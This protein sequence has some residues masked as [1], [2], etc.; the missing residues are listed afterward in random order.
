MSPFEK[1]APDANDS[2]ASQPQQEITGKTISEPHDVLDD[3]VQPQQKPLNV[4]P[5]DLGNIVGPPQL[6]AEQNPNDLFGANHVGLAVNV[7]PPQLDAKQNPIDLF[8]SN[9]GGVADVVAAPPLNAEQNQNDLFG[10]NLELFSTPTPPPRGNKKEKVAVEESS[11]S[12]DDADTPHFKYPYA[13]DSD[14]P[15]SENVAPAMNGI[16]LFAAANN[17][18]GGN[19]DVKATQNSADL[20]S[21]DPFSALASNKSAPDPFLQNSTDGATTGSTDP[22]DL[23]AAPPSQN[24]NSTSAKD[25]FDLFA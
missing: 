9:Q 20:F 7:G 12:E 16:D 18:N 5:F 11:S 19:Q 1:G 4:D 3:F 13:D 21:L 23:F 17:S 10:A 22:F 8:D 2:V 24:F 14:L 15:K 6:I 25:P